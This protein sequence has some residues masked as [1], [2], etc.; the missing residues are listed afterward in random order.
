MEWTETP[1]SSNLARFGYDASSQI[2]TVDFK[3]GGSYDYFDVPPGTHESMKS[4]ASK[5]Q[6]LATIIKGT[7]RYAKR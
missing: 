2:L 3:N 7:Y 1:D 4:A 5:G 6:F